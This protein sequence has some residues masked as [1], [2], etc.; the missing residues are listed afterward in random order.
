MNQR[1]KIQQKP[2]RGTRK[3]SQF[4]QLMK[5]R[6]DMADFAN[7]VNKNIEMLGN[8][9]TDMS[10]KFDILQGCQDIDEL[11][12]TMRKLPMLTMKK[13][14]MNMLK[15]F[16]AQLKEGIAKD[17]ELTE[18]ELESTVL[19]IS[20]VLLQLQIDVDDVDLE[21]VQAEKIFKDQLPV[22]LDR[23]REKIEEWAKKNEPTEEEMQEVKDKN[24]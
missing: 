16:F 14:S 2:K 19:K 11:F 21:Y 20:S 9:I 7:S 10:T 22:I 1:T 17:R 4:N 8:A 13:R 15:G 3:N 6:Q 12:D 5:L 23:V 24:E 18:E